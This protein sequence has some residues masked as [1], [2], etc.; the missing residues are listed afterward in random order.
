MNQKRESKHHIHPKRKTDMKLFKRPSIDE[1]KIYN[2]IK[3]VYDELQNHQLH[4]SGG[5]V[6]R[7]MEKFIHA[8]KQINT[9]VYNRKKSNLTQKDVE[10]LLDHLMHKLKVL[11]NIVHQVD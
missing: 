5:S 8:L 2:N 3:A 1:K 4:D 6:Y 7:D 9:F 11:K 10:I